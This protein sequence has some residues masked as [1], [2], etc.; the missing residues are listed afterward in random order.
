MSREANPLY[1]RLTHGAIPS[2]IPVAVGGSVGLVVTIIALMAPLTGRDLASTLMLYGMLILLAVTPVITGAFAGQMVV[3]ELA[4][5]EYAL[6]RLT[7]LSAEIVVDAFYRTALHRLRILYAVL[8]GWLAATAIQVLIYEVSTPDQTLPSALLETMVWVV[9]G[10]GLA[11]NNLLA[12]A[13]GV[14]AG[15]RFRS[16]ATTVA[17]A[18][19]FAVGPVVIVLAVLSPNWESGEWFPVEFFVIPITFLCMLFAPLFFTGLV[20][21]AARRW[22]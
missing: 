12:A 3:R 18:I 22:A 19:L 8:I 16:E 1:I 17:P 14:Y 9:I 6:L 21:R 20:L 5:E 13:V 10:L 15:L 2:R 4:N 11:S 7:N